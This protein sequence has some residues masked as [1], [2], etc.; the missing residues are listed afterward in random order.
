MAR[1]TEPDPEPDSDDFRD[2]EATEGAAPSSQT[3][4]P[5]SEDN[6]ERAAS[7]ETDQNPQ[8]Y[9]PASTLQ[10]GNPTTEDDL[11]MFLG[12]KDIWQDIWSAVKEAQR[13][14]VSKHIQTEIMADMAKS[15]TR[16]KRSYEKGHKEH[17]TDDLNKEIESR[18]KGL[19]EKVRSLSVAS[20]GTGQAAGKLVQDVYVTI[21]PAGI[22]LLKRAMRYRVLRTT[23]RKAYSLE[24]LEEIMQIQGFL[25]DICS[26]VIDWGI[27]PA[28]SFPITRNIKQKAYPNLRIFHQHFQQIFKEQRVDE[29]RTFNSI[30]YAAEAAEPDTPEAVRRARRDAEDDY[31][32]KMQRAMRIGNRR[33]YRDVDAVPR[34]LFP[35]S[36]SGRRTRTPERSVER[37]GVEWTDEQDQ[38]LIDQLL[39]NAAIRQLSG[40]C[41]YT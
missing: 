7:P 26:K 41:G 22:R 28:T 18:L 37:R 17:F 38:A 25:L 6:T 10:N 24:G 11:K 12:K 33:L 13:S 8:D 5:D 35:S 36:S 4:L 9:E 30:N 14:E 32:L 39:H 23:S 2:I 27:K 20:A 29:K 16:V 19:K 21:V 1:S 31:L 34:T 40:T 3:I 15:I